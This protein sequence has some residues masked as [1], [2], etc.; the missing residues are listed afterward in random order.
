M[1][2]KCTSMKHPVLSWIT[3]TFLS[4]F[5]TTSIPSP[6]PSL[7]KFYHHH[8][9]TNRPY[10]LSLGHD[11]IVKIRRRPS[12][13]SCVYYSAFTYSVSLISWQPKKMRVLL[14]LTKY[15]GLHTWSR[16]TSILAITVTHTSVRLSRCTI[17]LVS[18][19]SRL[20][21]FQRVTVHVLLSRLR[22][23]THRL[24]CKF[25]DTTHT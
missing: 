21:T 14:V 24:N 16:A 5:S 4:G 8:H 18:V 23:M 19:P 2:L 3:I 9:P 20:P 15:A 7:P 11:T 12:K 10:T 22:A 1:T 6:L 13:H 17:L 25:R